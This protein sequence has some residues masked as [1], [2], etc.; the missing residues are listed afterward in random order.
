MHA[1]IAISIQHVSRMTETPEDNTF[2]HQVMTYKKSATDLCSAA[3]Q[4]V[5]K[6]ARKPVLDSIL[7]LF[8]LDVSELKLH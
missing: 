4:A 8:A 1:V 6:M 7:V 2:S 5:S 3:L